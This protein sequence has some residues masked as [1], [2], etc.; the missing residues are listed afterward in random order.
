M[1]VD[2]AADGYNEGLFLG[3]VRAQADIRSISFKGNGVVVDNL[4]FT[5]P[6]PEA[7]T[8]AMLSAGLL[9]LGFLG[10]RRGA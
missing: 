4:A 5:T 2:T 1:V 10:R 6:V 8:W 3:I 9:A 7:G